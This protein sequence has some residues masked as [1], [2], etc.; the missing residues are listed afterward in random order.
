MRSPRVLMAGTLVL[1]LL[2]GCGLTT[3]NVSILKVHEMMQDMEAI[4]LDEPELAPDLPETG[5]LV[6][7]KTD[8]TIQVT[9]RKNKEQSITV[10]P[11]G[12]AAMALEPGSYHYTIAADE[13]AAGGKSKKIYIALRGYKKIVGKILYIY[14]VVT[15]QEVV[16]EKELEELRS[17]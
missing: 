10:P 13:A 16:K 17:R 1:A 4:E 7:N 12:S 8:T 3:Y 15:K 6:H 9:V 14:D 2:A 5:I 11:G